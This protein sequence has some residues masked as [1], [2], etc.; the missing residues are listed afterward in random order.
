MARIRSVHPGLF[1]DDAFA[2]L[3]DA[4]QVF[5]IGLWTECDDQGAFEWKPG[6]LKLRLRPGKD[7]PIEPIMEELEAANFIKSY[8]HGG[9]K[10]GLVRNFRRFQRPKKPNSVHFIPPEY[11]TYVGLIDESSEPVDDDAVPV[12]PKGELGPV[13]ARPVPPKGEKSIQMEDVG[14]RRKEDIPPSSAALP[15]RDAFEATDAALRKVPGIEK[16]PV[17]AAPVIAPIWKLVEQGYSLERQIIPSIRKRLQRDNGKAISD[18][19]YFVPGIIEDAR[20]ASAPGAIP[21]AIADEKWAERMETA[22]RKK[23][24]DVKWDAMP[25]RTG[26]RVPPH[27]LKPGDGEGWT[28]WRPER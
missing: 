21:D 20:A 3:S 13:K 17:F 24:W 4:A 10:L 19:G 25:G 5:I 26:C 12:P 28:E 11:R 16:H 23:Q 18:W 6:S 9:R 7:G 27:L 22:R 15:P 14:C 8:E 2:F 1:T